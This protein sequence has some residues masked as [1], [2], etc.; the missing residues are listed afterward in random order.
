M[1]ETPVFPLKTVLFPNGYLPLRIF[2]P[3]YLD[4][5]SACTKNNTGFAVCLISQGDEV[6]SGA[7]IHHIG[8]YANIVDFEP[9][10]NGMLSIMAKG[11]RKIEVYS[12][13]SEKNGLMYANIDYLKSEV[14]ETLAEEHQGLV[15]VLKEIMSHPGYKDYQQSVHLEDAREVGYRLAE[16]LPISL[17]QQQQLLEMDQP[18]KR[19]SKI[20]SMLSGLEDSFLA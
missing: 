15:N 6:G 3:R 1:I 8:T 18:R 14:S 2:E 5:V 12:S 16:M 17:L 10:A 20:V 9:L 13:W 19:L 7:R 4:M 11:E